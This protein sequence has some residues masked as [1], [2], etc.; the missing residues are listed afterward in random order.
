M[1]GRDGIKQEVS[2]EELDWGRNK[3]S[4]EIWSTSAMSVEKPGGQAQ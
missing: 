3:Q 2:W 1:Q 4:L